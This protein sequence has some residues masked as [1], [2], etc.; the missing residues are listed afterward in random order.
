MTWLKLLNRCPFW[1]S[2]SSTTEGIVRSIVCR[3]T[4]TSSLDWFFQRFSTEY[5]H[6]HQL[7]IWCDNMMWCDT[8]FIYMFIRDMIWYDV[9][10]YDMMWYDTMWYIH[11]LWY[12]AIWSDMIWY[13]TLWYDMMWYYMICDVIWYDRTYMKHHCEYDNTNTSMCYDFMSYRKMWWQW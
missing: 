11:V 3:E 5:L 4:P 12:V 13:D 1:W 2:V 9:M 6:T 10:W 8:I 7:M